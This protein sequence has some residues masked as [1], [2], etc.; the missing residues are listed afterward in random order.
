[1]PHV[2]HMLEVGD[3]LRYRRPSSTAAM[4]NSR[5]PLEMMDRRHHAL[6]AKAVERPEQRAIELAAAGAA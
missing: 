4:A 2:E 5:R 1:M 3:R 6:A